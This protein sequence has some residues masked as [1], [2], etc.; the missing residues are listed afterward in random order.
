MI[1]RKTGKRSAGGGDLLG[2]ARAGLRNAKTRDHFAQF[3]TRCNMAQTDFADLGK[4]KQG[5]ALGKQLTVN[6][7]LA[8]A[9]IAPLV[10][11]EKEGLALINGTD[12][13]LGMLLLAL[14][15]LSVL[16]LT[17]DVAAAMSIESQLGK[18]EAIANRVAKA[19]LDVDVEVDGGI[20]AVT[21]R[22]AQDA[23]ADVLVAG[24]ATFRGGPAC[25]ADNIRQLRGA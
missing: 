21:A 7:A 2:K 3:L 10:L 24:T 6:H 4:I 8:E 17:A 9:G 14:H 23:G 12:G 25:Y 11:R 15:D 1:T 22:R 20:D 16:L 18:I 19:G 13:M 5:Q